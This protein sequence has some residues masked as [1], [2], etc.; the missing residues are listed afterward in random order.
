MKKLLTLTACLSIIAAVGCKK[1]SKN[2]IPGQPYRVV[3]MASPVDDFVTGLF[4]EQNKANVIAVFDGDKTFTLYLGTDP[5]YRFAAAAMDFDQFQ[6]M[7]LQ[8]AVPVQH[9]DNHVGYLLRKL[10]GD[11]EMRRV[12]RGTKKN[13]R[14]GI[15]LNDTGTDN[16][17]MELA[18]ID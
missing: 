3:A 4:G 11:Y 12:T 15:E 7:R 17:V 9:Q 14:A 6:K 13:E 2:L 16:V 5:N 10:S 1:S 18:I 8:F